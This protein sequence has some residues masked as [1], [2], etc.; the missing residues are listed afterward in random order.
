MKMQI[1]LSWESIRDIQIALNNYFKSIIY[2]EILYI[3]KVSTLTI[4]IND[5]FILF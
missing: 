3:F 1:S 4:D 5:K 2:L